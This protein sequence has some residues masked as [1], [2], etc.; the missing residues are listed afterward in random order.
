MMSLSTSWTSDPEVGTFSDAAVEDAT[1][2]APATTTDDQ[3]VTLTLVATDNDGVTASDDVMITVPGTD[4][5]VSIQTEDQDVAGGTVLP[6]LATSSDDVAEYAWTSDPAVGTFSDAAV[7]DATWTAPATTTDDQ[8]V[9]LTLVATDNDGVTASDDVMI[10]VP[11]ADPTVSIQTEDQ[12][13]AGGTVLPLLA[14]SSDDVAE[15]AWTAD[16]AVGTFSD[17]AVEDATWT[18]PATTTDDQVVTLTL[19]VTDNDD[20]TATAS[21]DVMI[22]VPGADP[23]VSIQTED[24]DVAGGTVLPLL[25]TSSDD[26][27]EYAWTAD[28][29][30]GTFSDAAVEDATWTAPATTTDDQVVTLT[31]V[32]TDNDGVTASDDVTITVPGTVTVPGVSGG[33][34]LS[35][36][37]VDDGPSHDGTGN[38][39]RGNNDGIAQSG[40]TIELYVSIRNDGELPLTGLSGELIE[41]D[42]W[43]RVLY[44]AS[45]G[46]PDVAAGAIQENRFDWDLR[47]SPDAPNGHEFSF[48][49]RLTA[50]EGGP[51]EVPVTVPIGGASPPGVPVLS[52]VR[53]DDGPSHDG[54]GNDS[55]G[56]N[57]GI[58]QCGETIELYVSIRNDGELPL[59]GLSGELIE[60]DPWVRV[61]YN[62]S[63]RYPDVTAGSIQ[64]NRRD[65]DLRVSPDAPNGH[66]FS[67]MIRLT[68]DEGG[69]WEVPVTVP[70]ACG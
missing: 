58:A 7:E 10:T 15:Y 3:V 24:Q 66:E 1:W 31:L 12:D 34:V 54:T 21:D 69:P 51:W 47:V 65:W 68:A 63:S 23:T 19:T 67:F 16:P 43:V 61:L 4:P 9:T 45:S 35:S 38:D 41:T 32:A 30:V 18:A 2:T 59:T 17:A 8:V 40:E 49:I 48:M 28:P 64:E 42:P 37:R 53:V 29:A 5:T 60:T 6:L 46:Y 56:N 11:G 70:I 44:N 22:T 52:S 39:S 62:A 20:A 27:A 36:V 50:D 55:R 33:P 13:V 26:V 25:A 14:T 57:D